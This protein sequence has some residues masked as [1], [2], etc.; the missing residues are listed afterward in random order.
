MLIKVLK[1]NGKQ[2]QNYFLGLK[3]AVAGQK[4][5]FNLYISSLFECF[6]ASQ[7]PREYLERS[8]V[9]HHL[10]LDLERS[11]AIFLRL[12]RNFN[13]AEAG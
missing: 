3:N 5:F 13:L 4:I 7:F 8:L 9:A 10:E 2:E 1:S 6:T 11:A 12:Q